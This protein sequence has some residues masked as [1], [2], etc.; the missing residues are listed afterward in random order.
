MG[1]G[2]LMT[3]TDGEIAEVPYEWDLLKIRPLE[4]APREPGGVW[5][6]LK[7]GAGGSVPRSSV[8]KKSHAS[9]DS[10]T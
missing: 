6:W 2:K 7:L 1:K 8:Q 9:T 4:Q 5:K 3:L 10:Q